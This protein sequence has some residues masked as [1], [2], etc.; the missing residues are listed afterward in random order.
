MNATLSDPPITQ[1]I[2]NANFARSDT[3]LITQAPSL[4]RSDAVPL[5]SN[6]NTD[7]T[8]VGSEDFLPDV[9]QV[10]ISC[11]RLD[12]QTL[13]VDDKV[14]PNTPL[15][16]GKRKFVDSAEMAPDYKRT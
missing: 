3:T 12:Q 8:R 13:S 5:E 14:R 9:V 16:R 11:E 6:Q 10:A 7:L 15:K 4:T 2:S 1:V